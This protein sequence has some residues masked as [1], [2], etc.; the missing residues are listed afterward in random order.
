MRKLSSVLQTV[1]KE[2]MCELINYK[3]TDKKLKLTQKVNNGHLLQFT[4]RPLFNF[5]FDG[6][7]FSFETS[8][9]D[10]TVWGCVFACQLGLYH[11]YLENGANLTGDKRKTREKTKMHIGATGTKIHSTENNKKQHFLVVL[12]LC[13]TRGSNFSAGAWAQVLCHS[14]FLCFHPEGTNQYYH[15]HYHFIIVIIII[16]IIIIIKK[17]SLDCREF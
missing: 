6:H 10:E 9:I 4:V 14:I 5:L 7:V 1:N 8:R 17:L 13:C 3:H 11:G 16:I 15:Y 2:G 12:I